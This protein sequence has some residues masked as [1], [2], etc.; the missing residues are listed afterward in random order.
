[1]GHDDVKPWIWLK[2]AEARPLLEAVEEL[3]GPTDPASIDRIRGAF[4]DAPVNEAI[5]LVLAR[6]RAEGKFPG[7]AGRLFCDRQGVE[8]ATSLRVAEHKAARFGSAG[9][10][11]LCCG[12]GG[13]TM[14]LARRGPTVGVDHAPHRAW[15]CGVN[16]EV[17]TRVE[18]VTKTGIDH[19]LVHVDPARREESQG[20][21]SWRLSDLRPG[22]EEIGSILNQCEGGAVKLGPGLP[23]DFELPGHASTLEFIAEDQKLVQAVAWVGALADGDG[24]RRAT[25]LGPDMSIEGFPDSPP[26]GGEAV[27]GRHLWVPH[28]V[29]ERAE[30][31][32]AALADAEALELARGLGILIAEEPPGNSWFAGYR[33]E[34]VL[35]PRLGKVSSWLKKHDAGRVVVRTRDGAI[36][37]DEW[38]KRLLGD[39]HVS[40]TVFGL[41]LGKRIV[42]IIT[43]EVVP[44]HSS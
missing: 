15:M 44:D 36:D 19:P 33:I 17:D 5:Q 21:R 2:S 12:I 4:P 6:R 40:F 11:D 16:A 42:A 10:L 18:D 30:L 24:L 37:A 3:S 1:V 41:R 34:E 26:G 38:T 28:P 8:Q 9:V 32:P 20:R 25:V 23:R 31:I 27:A 13:D 43:R 29:L 14:S 39:G 7:I 22:L 35:P